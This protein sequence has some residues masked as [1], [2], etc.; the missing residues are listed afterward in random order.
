[1]GYPLPPPEQQQLAYEQGIAAQVVRPVEN[2]LGRFA[3]QAAAAYV[4]LAGGLDRP[5]P[6]QHQP[7][8]REVL[9]RLLSVVTFGLSDL[10][11]GLVGEGSPELTQSV[12]QLDERAN[13]QVANAAL[14]ATTAP[15]HSWEDTL[16][17][18]GKARRAVNTAEQTARWAANR[19]L[20]EDIRAQA[21][22]FG[23]QLL[24]VAERNACLH[25]LAY[26]GQVT[27]SRGLFPA[28]LTFYVGADGQLKPLNTGPV[29]SPPLHP[30]CRCRL[31][32]WMGYDLVG[33]PDAA[34]LQDLPSV[35]RREAQR[36]VL[37]G[38]SGHSSEPAGLR[39]ADS[40]LQRA[41]R[42][43]FG[44]SVLRRARE[45]VRAGQFVSA[46]RVR[47]R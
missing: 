1:V 9:L 3:Q 23:G 24:W 27:D 25:C 10:L 44:E 16:Q 8:Y 37:R 5:L 12:N 17:V 46:G 4:V 13:G 22:R 32:V 20:A 47:R 6:E 19:R 36:S 30:N 40:L 43:A 33:F 2:Q 34:D 42:V 28:G 31:Q 15:L 41:D 21:T 11:R 26:A 45:D 35:L 14:F 39:A 29:Q 38:F 7:Q 18:V